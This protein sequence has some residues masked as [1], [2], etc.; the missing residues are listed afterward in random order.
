MPEKDYLPSDAPLQTVTVISGTGPGGMAPIPSGTIAQT[1]GAHVPN[2]FVKSV[3]PSIALAVRF[4]NTFLT[5][6]VGFV[7][8]APLIAKITGMELFEFNDLKDL[9]LRSTIAALCPSIIGFAKD[10][11]TIFSR[12]ENKFP[13][14]TGNV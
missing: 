3:T 11:T 13:I 5:A 8:A 2:V 7:T 4:G 10:L 9:V 1:P 14:A 6:W 12:L